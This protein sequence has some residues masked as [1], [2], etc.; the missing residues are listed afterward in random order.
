MLEQYTKQ[1]Q[2]KHTR[3][4]PKRRLNGNPTPRDRA[5]VRERSGNRCER[6]GRHEKAVMRLEM[7]HIIRRSQG[8]PGRPWNLLHLCGPATDSRTCHHWVDYTREG[9]EW[10][11]DFQRKYLL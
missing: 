5:E 1:M 6:C 2:L 7:A 11:L 4:K 9:K 8:G 3:I 10:A